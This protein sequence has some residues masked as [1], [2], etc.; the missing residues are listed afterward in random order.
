MVGLWPVFR[1]ELADNFSSRRFVITLALVCITGLAATNVAAQTIRNEITAS[2]RSGFVFLRLFTASGDVLPSFIFFLSFLGPLVGLALGFDAINSEF[3]R[4]TLSRVLAQ[5]IYR[6]ALVNG[7]FAAGLTTIAIM[8]LA[9]GLLLAGLGLRAIGVPPTFEEG[10]RLL[11]FFVMTIIYVAFWMSLAILFSILFRQA[12]TSALA[13]MAV[14]I[15]STFFI[16]M[17][18]TLLSDAIVPLNPQ[19]TVE[20]QIRHEQTRQLLARVSPSTLYQES[21]IAVLTPRVR[22]LGPVLVTEIQ[23]MVDAP[24]SLTQSLIVIWPQA[25][26]LIAL[27]A[28]CFAAS[29]LRFMRQEIRAP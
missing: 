4:G 18:A 22:S 1:K 3:N 17:F 8:I 21:T 28:I 7:K 14:W 10:V 11:I 16:G 27:T 25:V 5:P 26:M 19:S 29:Y 6:D 15:V 13:G 2:D 23:R 24:L 9:T 20:T 12:A